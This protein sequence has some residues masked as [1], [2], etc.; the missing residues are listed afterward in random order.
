MDWSRSQDYK[1]S[2]ESPAHDSFG[3]QTGNF[4]FSDLE[5]VICIAMYLWAEQPLWTG[6]RTLTDAS[7]DRRGSRVRLLERREAKKAGGDPILR[8]RP[9]TVYKIPARVSS[10]TSRIQYLGALCG[11]FFFLYIFFFYL[12]HLNYSS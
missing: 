7:A 8:P 12:P 1:T 6:C 3:I 11:W 10:P 5:G 9:G 2:R 4:F